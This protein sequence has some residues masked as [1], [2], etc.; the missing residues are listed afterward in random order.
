MG[1]GDRST[2]FG[3]YKA[4]EWVINDL[5]GLKSWIPRQWRKLRITLIYNTESPK[6]SG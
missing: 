6:G 2:S 3:D 1:K 4:G 5:A